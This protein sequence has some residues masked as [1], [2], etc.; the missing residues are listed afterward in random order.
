MPQN[1]TEA[2][3]VFVLRGVQAGLAMMPTLLVGLL[4]AGV[5][6]AAVSD[7]LLRRWLDRGNAGDLLR[8][9]V[10]SIL[11]PV[12]A[13][14]VL[15]VL[16][17]LRRRR[18]R[19]AV[20]V[21]VALS[22]GV[23]N[24]WSLVWLIDKTG[25]RQAAVLMAGLALFATISAA[26]AAWLFRSAAAT[27]LN[28]RASET[29]LAGAVHAAATSARQQTLWADILFGLAG[30]SLLAVFL[31][32]GELGHLFLER[33]WD[34]AALLLAI[35]VAAYSTPEAIVMQAA[36]AT[37]NGALPGLVLPLLVL[38]AGV[39]LGHLSFF[40]RCTGAWRTVVWG[41]ACLIV[42]A[43][44]AFASDRALLD[45]R[46]P[47]ED[48]HALDAWGRPWKLIHEPGGP[49]AGLWATLRHT[50]SR[51]QAASAVAVVGLVVGG[52][53]LASS[54]RADQ[55]SSASGALR[56]PLPRWA[57][58]AAGVATLLGCGV[59]AV[60]AYFPPPAVALG[61]LREADG[62]LFFAV[63][64]GDRAAALAAIDKLD[65][66]AAQ[67]NTSIRIRPGAPR[68][69]GDMVGDYRLS[70][71][72]LRATLSAGEPV[73]TVALKTQVVEVSR[74][75]RAC[76]RVAELP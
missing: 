26:V 20:L 62:E 10:L 30:L 54:L 8:A 39:T 46:Q 68:S 64:T 24:P 63:Q 32:P 66:L 65:R 25:P 70:L 34:H 58:V 17:E 56:R 35:P 36:A 7:R 18:V 15:P 4:L 50:T 14:G 45:G 3:F 11:T 9:L 48:S 44:L 51:G 47:E 41:V 40:R 31:P 1:F 43:A 49:T 69:L 67:A 38:G 75:L 52:R 22:A 12:C 37:E 16:A 29:G 28:E 74:K 27:E 42:M 21:V 55:G 60:Y 61:A 23:C 73:D 59:G 76:T 13:L 2:F 19:P 53:R 57:V 6:R 71:L 72:A 5:L 33:E